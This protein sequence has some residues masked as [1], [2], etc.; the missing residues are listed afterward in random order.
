MI[1]ARPTPLL[2]AV[3]IVSILGM[4]VAEDAAAELGCRFDP[5]AHLLAISVTS[6]GINS[7]G[8]VRRSGDSIRISEFTGGR[9]VPCDGG[10]PTV[11]NTDLVKVA[12]KGTLASID[13]EL[14]GGSFAPGA[15]AEVDG[16]SEIEFTVS[17]AGSVTVEGT[18]GADHLRYLTADGLSGVDLNPGADDR[19][20]DVSIEGN[21]IAPPVF[22]ETG[23]GPDTIDVVGR[24][25]FGIVADGGAGDDSLLA[26]NAPSGAALEGGRGNDRIVGS[27][28]ANLIVP[29]AGSDVVEAL[30]GE[31]IVLLGRDGHRDG[32]DCGAGA[33]KSDLGD[34]FDRLRSCEHREHVHLPASL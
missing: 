9:V 29:G 17:G 34:R 19:D 3:A 1:S 5:A 26:R 15:T 31:D 11:T 2:L 13:V 32:I 10:V 6:S 12:T 33:D 28:S 4:V 20:V 8:V 25:A 24:P 23:P 21:G 7:E 16:S 22:L 14:Q 18:S 27:A 30:G